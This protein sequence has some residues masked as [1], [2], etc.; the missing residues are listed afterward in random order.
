M[1]DPL[2]REV[3][4]PAK[5][6]VE[7]IKAIEALREGLLFLNLAEFRHSQIY[8]TRDCNSK[9]RYSLYLPRVR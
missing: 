1:E 8:L 9:D 4:L 6:I 5:K 3:T 7:L 2:A